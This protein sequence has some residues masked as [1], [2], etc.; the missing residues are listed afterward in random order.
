[1]TLWTRRTDMAA[2]K[3]FEENMARLE[4]IVTLLEKGDAQ[5]TDSLALF[6][7][8][9]KLAAQCRKEWYGEDRRVDRLM[10]A[11]EGARLESIFLGEKCH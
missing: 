3:T 1:M 11:S 4:Q 6:E 2:K 8:G 7:E 5:L 9:T 10:R